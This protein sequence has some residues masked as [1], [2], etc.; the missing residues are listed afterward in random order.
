MS[1]HGTMM[2]CGNYK[3]ELKEI[4]KVLNSLNFVGEKLKFTVVRDEIVAKGCGKCAIPGE[5]V[6]NG[7]KSEEVEFKWLSENISPLLTEGRLEIVAFWPEAY[8]L[9]T[10]LAIHSD[11]FVESHMHCGRGSHVESRR[12]PY[13]QPKAN[14]HR[15]P[16]TSALNVNR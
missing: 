10:V 2:V 8:D 12:G 15:R 14:P 13:Y 3:G 7:R 11:G 9:I 6:L 4:A 5:S 1:M 16:Y